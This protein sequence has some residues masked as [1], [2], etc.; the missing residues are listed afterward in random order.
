LAAEIEAICELPKGA[1][2]GKA[3]IP[4]EAMPKMACAVEEAR[5][6]GVTFGFISNPVDPNAQTH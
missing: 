2:A 5:K 1:L 4:G 3:P 6:R